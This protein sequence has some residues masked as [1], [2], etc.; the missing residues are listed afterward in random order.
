LLTIARHAHIYGIDL[1]SRK[2]LVAH[3]RAQEDIASYIGADAV[4]YQ[5][6]DDLQGACADLSPRG[7]AQQFE[8]GVFCGRYITPVDDAYLAH[9]EQVRSN[10]QRFKERERARLAI[11]N[12]VSMGNV[13]ARRL[14]NGD[15]A[16]AGVHY[17][18]AGRAEVGDFGSA[19]NIGAMEEEAGSET[20]QDPTPEV[21]DRMDINLHNL[22]DYP[23]R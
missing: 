7:S 1:A 23:E 11:A 3:Q 5:T 18:T 22:G 10:A 4:I 21:R 20:R 8:I 9:L 12:G 19:G 2:E 13:V 14:T 17:A 6:L 16:A 15:T